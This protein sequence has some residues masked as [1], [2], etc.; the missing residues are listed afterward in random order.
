MEN[1]SLKQ[2]SQDQK[3]AV[4]HVTPTKP[5]KQPWRREGRYIYSPGRSFPICEVS[6]Y[7]VRQT[8]VDAANAELIVRAVN[9][10]DALV[11]ALSELMLRAELAREELRQAGDIRWQY[12]GT[13]Q[14]EAAL[15]LVRAEG[16]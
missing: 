13:K 14:A 3:L 2:D 10:H 8:G 16:R 12:L 15:K 1:T 7:G 11:E 6:T 5:L 9:A 4:P